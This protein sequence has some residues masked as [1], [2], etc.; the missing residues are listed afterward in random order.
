MDKFYKITV[1][2]IYASFS[3]RKNVLESEFNHFIYYLY[4]LIEEK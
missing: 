1:I 4:N 3:E 2:I